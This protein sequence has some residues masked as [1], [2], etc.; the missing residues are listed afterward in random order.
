MEE[1]VATG[2]RQNDILWKGMIE[3]VFD[4]LL[5]FVFPE[6]ESIFD[7]DQGFEHLDK[8]LTM[9]NP[10][11]ESKADTR[12]VD[13]LIK[14]FLKNGSEEWVLCHIEVQAANDKEF[15][16]RMYRYH[17]RIYDR[18]E[19]QLTAIAIFSGK[20]GNK[21]P[22]KYYREF[23]GTEITYKYNTLCLLDL[24]DRELASSSNPFALVLL[25]AKMA[26]KK[27][28]DLDEVLLQKKESIANLLIKKGFS[29]N[30]TNAIL[31]FLK[32]YVPFEKPETYHN[33]DLEIDRLTGKTNTMGIIEQV[34]QMKLDE[35][36]SEAREKGREEGRE[37]GREDAIKDFT[38]SLLDS[39]AMSIKE[40]ANLVGVSEAFVNN[41]KAGIAQ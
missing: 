9:V 8:E 41:L 27:W 19:Q 21:L 23:Q 1:T 39:T 22:K 18:Y 17:A 26:L 16:K 29:E 32:R 20:D 36:R 2:R 10:A 34:K 28:K 25:A 15:A 31:L 6:A 3:E 37:E 12:I 33:F 24:D 4:D 35:A 11:P 40:I 30:K 13:K 5:R 38:R 14:V 7:L